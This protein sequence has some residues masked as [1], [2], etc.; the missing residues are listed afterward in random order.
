MDPPS[1]LIAAAAPSEIA[2]LDFVRARVSREM[3]R[4][5]AMNDYGNN[6]QI[7]ELAIL[8]QL[9]PNPVLGVVEYDLK[10]ALELEQWS[11]PRSADTAGHLKRLLACIILLR[12]AAFVSSDDP[13]GDIEKSPGKIIW[14]VRSSIMLG[15]QASRQGLGFLLWLHGKQGDPRLRAFVSFGALLL[16]IQEDLC[17]SNLLDTSTWVEHEEKVAREQLHPL[18]I[19]SATWLLGLSSYEDC[20]GRREPAEF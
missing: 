7:R 3:I 2:L 12:N 11:Y 18:E 17:G 15:S 5:I 1:D 9:A 13:H 8:E 14:L 19:N 6:A 10:E 4:E 16:Q 20:G